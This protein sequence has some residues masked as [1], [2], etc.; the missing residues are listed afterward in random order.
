MAVSE[1]SI[2]N[3]AIRRIGA[4]PITSLAGT[5]HMSVL[6]NTLYEPARDDLLYSHPWNFAIARDSL[7]ADVATPDFEYTVQYSLPSDC[8][9]VLRLNNT[10]DDYR[11]EGR[12]IL[13]DVTAPLKMIYI[14]KETDPTKF[15]SGFAECLALK[16]AQDMGY[17]LAANASMVRGLSEQLK[18]KL[19]QTKQYDAQEGNPRQ[20]EADDWTDGL[21]GP[22]ATIIT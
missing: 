8:L 3:R 12:K 20:F 6:C 7:S 21:T 13:C 4:E 2:C 10:K 22:S 5:D 11:I 17:A 9:R 19:A 16:I 18:V 1:V 14:K 15:S